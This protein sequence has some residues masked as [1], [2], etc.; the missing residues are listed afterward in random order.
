MA[1]SPSRARKSRWVWSAA[2][3]LCAALMLTG[4]GILIARSLDSVL[5]GF[6][7]AD[8]VFILVVAVYAS[9]QGRTSERH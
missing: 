8:F 7:G 9:V 3:W 4:L 2:F 1:T 6:L 5:L